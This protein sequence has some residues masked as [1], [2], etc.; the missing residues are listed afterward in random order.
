VK[1]TARRP[2]VHVAADDPSL[3]PHAGLLHVGE[4]VAA[5]GLTH[6]IDQALP[7]FKRRN[8]GLSPGKFLVSVAES[9]FVGGDCLSDVEALRRDEAGAALR[10][11]AEAPAPTT[12]G[13]YFR[14]FRLPDLWK[15]EEAVAE[16]G[17]A[18]DRMLGLA[19]GVVTLDADSTHTEV[20]GAAKQGASWNYE[21]KRTYQPLVVFWAE[22]GRSLVADLLPGGAQPKARAPRLIARAIKLLPEGATEI[23]LRADSGFYSAEVI[24]ACRRRGIRFSISA[25][26]ST[27]VWRALE[28]LSD[29]DFRPA[30]DMEGAEVACTTYEMHGVGAVRLIVRRVKIDAST[31][32]SVRGR[33]RRTIPRDQLQLALEGKLT[34]V[35][36]YS[37]IVT[38]LEGDAAEIEWWHRQ[39][40]GAEEL[41]KDAKLGVGMRRMPMGDARANAAWMQ[42]CLLALSLS[43]ML[44]QVDGLP[45]RPQGKRRRRELIRVPG[46]VVCSGR[47]LILHLP[48]S[49]PTVALFLSLYATL[50][51]L[52]PPG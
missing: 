27:G 31:L 21:G 39:R 25:V 34:T 41:F 42:T 17:N 8:R 14:R 40:A 24:K 28:G 1:T 50:R 29:Q 18:L 47:R 11:V 16:A 13:Q 19:P 10:A 51:A 6:R 9:V 23:R 30:R 33:R 20:F 38:D 44:H 49:L 26:R 7:G 32:P 5:T 37:F 52:G 36:A 45:S 35:Y 15:V 3:T 43:S 12:A 2:K 46:R 4:L 22:R 48:P